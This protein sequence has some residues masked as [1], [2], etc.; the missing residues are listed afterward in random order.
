MR[1]NQKGY[2]PDYPK[3]LVT[4]E[5]FRRITAKEQHSSQEFVS[6]PSGYTTVSYD[7]NGMAIGYSNK[8]EHF[9]YM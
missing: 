6:L 2:V 8:G 1:D 3:R 7:C 4:A 5:E 9:I